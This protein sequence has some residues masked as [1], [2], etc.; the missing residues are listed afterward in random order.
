[1]RLD[2]KLSQKVLILVT[3]P[4]VFM[5]VFVSTLAIL[6][7]KAEDA[8]WRERHYKDISN[9]CNSLITNFV[10]AG[11]NFAIYKSTNHSESFD[12]FNRL[13]DAIPEQIRTL[14]VLLRESKKPS[15]SINKSS[16][17]DIKCN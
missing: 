10:T 1:M 4:I 14:K 8:V 5:L 15:E 11:S 12:T 2:L 17:I 6:Q 3:I 13:T 16:R 9:E 7:K